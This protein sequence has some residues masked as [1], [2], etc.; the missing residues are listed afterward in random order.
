VL[1][2][3]FA[4]VLSLFSKQLVELRPRSLQRKQALLKIVERLLVVRHVITKDVQPSQQLDRIILEA[5]VL[6]FDEGEP[7]LAYKL[8][9]EACTNHE[10]V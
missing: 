9:A 6:C 8:L 10:K 1:A 4:E 2:E 7:L 3:D 5:S